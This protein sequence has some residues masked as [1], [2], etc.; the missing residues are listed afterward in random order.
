[1]ID[2]FLMEVFTRSIVNFIIDNRKEVDQLYSSLSAEEEHR[3]TDFLW[4]VV[5][6]SNS[7]LDVYPGDFVMEIVAGDL[8]KAVSYADDAAMK[9]I[10]LL[11]KARNDI[12]IEL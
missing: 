8:A 5:L 6:E 11:Y 4:D 2:D 1:M 10:P 7:A 3:F 12:K 9:M